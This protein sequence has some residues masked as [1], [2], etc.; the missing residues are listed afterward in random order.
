MLLDLYSLRWLIETIFKNWKSNL[1]FDKIHNVSSIQLRILLTSKFL[2]IILIQHLYSSVKPIVKKVFGKLLSFLKFSNFLAE[3]LYKINDLL[4]PTDLSINDEIR[5]IAYY[6]SYDKRKKR[7]NF[8]E[9]M[10]EI[11]NL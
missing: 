3:H 8:E 5:N 10:I 2:I 9:R 1:N 4:E 6:C 11:F 7:R